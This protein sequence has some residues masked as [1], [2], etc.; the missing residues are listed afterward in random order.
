MDGTPKLACPW[1]RTEESLGNV[2]ELQHVNLQVPDQLK[3]TAFY[4][5]ALGL[6]RDPYLMTGIDN[7]W[8]NA[9]I[10]QFHLPT[11]PAQVLRGTTGLVLP[12]RAQ[13]LH[14]LEDFHANTFHG[15]NHHSAFSDLHLVQSTSVM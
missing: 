14:R 2:V 11:G 10:S 8:A 13:L 3:A 9:G 5:S 1:D 6:T 12:D 7:M 15:S 4:I